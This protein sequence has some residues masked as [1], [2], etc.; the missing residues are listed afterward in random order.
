MQLR[1]KSHEIK[2]FHHVLILSNSVRKSSKLAETCPKMVKILIFK[3]LVFAHACLHGRPLFGHGP[4]PEPPAGAKDP[5]WRAHDPPLIFWT[6]QNLGVVKRI[7]VAQEGILNW[8]KVS[9]TLHVL[10]CTDGRGS[11]TGPSPPQGLEFLA[12]SS[13]KF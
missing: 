2:K 13:N 5:Q 8:F 4:T 9:C 10:A 3:P 7:N 6:V 11:V 1:N 12:H